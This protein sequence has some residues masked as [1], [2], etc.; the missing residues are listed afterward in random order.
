M[1]VCLLLKVVSSSA[2]QLL[3]WLDALGLCKVLQCSVLP[4][5]HCFSP[6]PVAWQQL[7]RCQRPHGPGRRGV[8][9]WPRE[10]DQADRACAGVAVT[11]A[12]LDATGSWSWALFAPSAFLF[13]TGVAVFTT[14]GSAELQQ[15]D[16]SAAGPFWCARL[17]CALVCRP[18]K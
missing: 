9:S 14:Y 11:G 10:L 18:N 6:H 1:R 7:A 17:S 5:V 3:P 8:R 15:F 13:V 2:C 4:D 12:L 16:G